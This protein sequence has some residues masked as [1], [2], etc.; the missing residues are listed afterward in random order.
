MVYNNRVITNTNIMK[1]TIILAIFALMFATVPN[2][3]NAGFDFG[4]LIDPACF[5][6]CDNEP[7]VVNNTNSNNVNS[8]VN[9]PGGVVNGAP[10]YNGG[11]P[12]YNYNN[13]NYSSQLGVTC[14]PTSS[15]ANV[16]DLVVWRA[17]A[18]GGNGNYY[19]TWSGTNGLDGNGSSVS[20]RYGSGGTKSASVI[21]SSGNQTVTRNCSSVEVYDYNDNYSNRN[22]RYDYDYDYDYNRNYSNRNYDYPLTVTCS[23]NTTFAPVGTSVTWQAYV[24][25]GNGNY[26]Y[27]WYGSDDIRGTSR[28]LDIRYNG[29]GTKTASVTVRS[30]TQNVT[31]QCSNSVLVG[32]PTGAYTNPYPTTPVYTAPVIKYVKEPVKIAEKES[33]TITTLSSLFSLEN[34]PWGWVAVLVILI[35]FFTVIY[36][37]YNKNKI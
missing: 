10:T 21:V 16:D 6:A 24:S 31:Q 15:R 2:H 12:N 14:Y 25:G 32:I 35:L 29:A 1:K 18:F 27:N 19:I 26:R 3:A 37:V 36:L 33:K 8:N 22:Y 23:A 13:D 5:F 4:R 20:K 28:S 9:S 17:S 34:V 11:T 7:N 30:G